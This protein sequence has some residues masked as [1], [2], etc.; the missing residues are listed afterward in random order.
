[1]H[2]TT[3]THTLTQ[4]LTKHN[5]AMQ[6]Q[7]QQ[8]RVGI[9]LPSK[10]LEKFFTSTQRLAGSLGDF[11]IFRLVYIFCRFYFLC[12]CS[13]EFSAHTFHIRK[14]PQNYATQ[15]EMHLKDKWI[16]SSASLPYR[17]PSMARPASV[18]RYL[19]P[20]PRQ[21][22]SLAHPY[23]RANTWVGALI[24]SQIF[25]AM[26][27]AAQWDKSNETGVCVWVWEWVCVFLVL[28]LL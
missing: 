26:R 21:P 1:M 28:K 7:Q 19:L 23:G 4:T 9:N 10:F 2:H 18:T 3:H 6:Q 20:S 22:Y 17:V 24:K 15:Y 16:L 13:L 11:L 14:N 12:C 5:N 27:Q 25:H 8:I